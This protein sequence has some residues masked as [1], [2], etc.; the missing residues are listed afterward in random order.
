MIQL[1][2]VL[3]MKTTMR[4]LWSAAIAQLVVGLPLLALI[5]PRQPLLICPS[6]P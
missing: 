4:R 2:C 6:K 1:E 5:T 3:M